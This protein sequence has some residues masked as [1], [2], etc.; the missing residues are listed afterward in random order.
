MLDDRTNMNCPL[1]F[2]SLTVCC[3]IPDFYRYFNSITYARTARVCVCI[4]FQSYGFEFGRLSVNYIF[5]LN[6]IK[7]V[8]CFVHFF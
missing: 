7:S 5:I 3:R 8:L 1:S 2:P 4:L 6:T